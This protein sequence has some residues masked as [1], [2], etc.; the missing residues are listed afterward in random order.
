MQSPRDILSRNREAIE[1]RV[2]GDLQ[3]WYTTVISSLAVRAFALYYREGLEDPA[4]VRR[5]SYLLFAGSVLSGASCASALY[6]GGA[7][8]GIVEQIVTLA[9]IGGLAAGSLGT[10]GALRG[11]YF[12]FMVPLLSLT[13]LWLWIAPIGSSSFLTVAAAVYAI[14]LLALGESFAGTLEDA[15]RLR[16]QNTALTDNLLAAQ[17][18]LNAEMTQ[19]RRAENAIAKYAEKLRHTN[20]SLQSEI[21]ERRKHEEQV[22][23]QALNIL[24]SEM[25]LRAVLENTFD[26][27]LSVQRDGTISSANP[28][29]GRLFRR[30]VDDLEGESIT[31]YVPDFDPATSAH[32]RLE[33]MGRTAEGREFPLSLAVAEMR[34]KEEVHLVCVI[35]DE[36]DAQLARDALVAA[37]DAAEAAN[38]AKSEFLSRMSHELRT[39]LNAILGFAQ[40]LQSDPDSPLAGDQDESVEQ[41]L[42][43][44]WHL[45]ELINEVLDLAKI[46]AGRIDAAVQDIALRD[47]IDDSLALVMPLAESRGISIVDAVDEPQTLVRSD[48]KRLKQV[49]LNLLS[50][51]IKYNRPDGRVTLETT[52]LSDGRYCRIVVA[53]TGKGLT[54]DELVTIFKP[55]TRVG[56]HTEEIEGTGIGLTITQKLLHLMG[57]DIGVESTLGEGSRFWVDI[58]LARPNAAGLPHQLTGEAEP[59]VVPIGSA[60]G[61]FTVLY[62]EDNAANVTLLRQLI[63]RQRPNIRLLSAPDGE[64][65]LDAAREHRPEL[66]LLDIGLPDMSGYEVLAALRAAPETADTPVIAVSANA[67]PEDVDQGLMAGFLR[68][69]TKPIDV[70]E[71]LGTVDRVLRSAA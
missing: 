66:I 41:I 27:L 64:R 30:P 37:R 38:R 68:Y 3:A 23:R 40:L 15:F 24:D 43:A 52:P 28:A 58:P 51:A 35:R 45:L 56:P 67:M 7:G 20:R 71:L 25:R 9:L 53:D 48:P 10:M 62:V 63:R 29:A 46:E 57:G 19:R 59:E 22:T 5:A 32:R 6:L 26:A 69:L 60:D 4:R 1:R 70:G 55:F 47:L 16:F 61:T 42:K 34:V 17:T 36:T 18:D 49:L 13:V 54:E 2:T 11:A 44:G 14:M 21:N 65:G 50:N 8:T 31:D 12:G 33:L 39:P